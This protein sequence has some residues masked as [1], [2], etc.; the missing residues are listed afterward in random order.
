MLSHKNLVATTL[1][2]MEQLQGDVMAKDDIHV[3]YLP[4]SHVF[5][6]LVQVTIYNIRDIYS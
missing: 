5:E 6:R 2:V 3:S 1:S 4:A